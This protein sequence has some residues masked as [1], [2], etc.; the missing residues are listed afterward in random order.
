MKRNSKVIVAGVAVLLV[1][2]IVVAAYSLSGAQAGSNPSCN[3]VKT[4][5]P[6]YLE[7]GLTHICATDSSSDGRLQ[8]TVHNY[9][10]ARAGDIQFHFAPNE[11]TPLPDDVFML[12]NVTVVNIGDGNTTIGAGWEAGLLN[13]TTEIPGVTNFIANATFPGTY[14]NITIPDHVGSNGCGCF[15]LPPS[16][17][18]DFWIF[19]YVPFGFDIK[20]GNVVQAQGFNLQIVSY[21][22]LGYGGTYEGGGSF[23]CVEVAC[24]HPDVQF[25]IETANIPE[26]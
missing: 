15:Y 12:V 9:H 7:S 4:N 22:E 23:G 21:R 19:F 13:G 5:W 11:Q 18:A 20:S 8:I 25:I 14:P 26:T 10:F 2:I 1:V 16:S 24:Q 17:K 3:F 6:S